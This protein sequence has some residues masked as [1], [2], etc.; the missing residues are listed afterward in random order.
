MEKKQGR[1]SLKKKKCYITIEWARTKNEYMTLYCSE[2]DNNCSDWLFTHSYL[3]FTAYTNYLNGSN[4]MSKG[5]GTIYTICRKPYMY[6]IIN[7][8]KA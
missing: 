1:A 2:C 5:L 6:W 4:V 3:N 8:G 7:T